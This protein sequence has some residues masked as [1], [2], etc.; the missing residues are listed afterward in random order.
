MRSH[1]SLV[2]LL[3]CLSFLVL[4]PAAAGADTRAGAVFTLSNDP[5]GNRVLIWERSANGS[6]HRAGSVATGG[7]GT[8]GSLGNQGALTL[9]A[10]DRWLYAVNPGS[11]EVSVFKVRGAHLTLMEVAPSGGDMPISVTARGHLV[12]VLNAGG[13]GNIAGFRRSSTGVLTPIVGSIEPLSG[14]ATGPAQIGF[15][16]N[17][18]RL[19]VTE[20]ATDRI[21]IYHLN[22]ADAA[23]A[24]HSRPSATATPFGFDFTSNGTLVVSE[25]AG[26][27]PDAG[28]TSSYRFGPSGGL[29]LVDGSVATTETA[30][31]WVVITDDDR[32]AYVTNTGSGTVSGY[33]ISAS[34]DLSLL[35]ADGVTASTG[36]GS[37]PIDA[38]LDGSSRHLY[39][40]LSGRDAIA[41]LLVRPD[42][43]LVE[44][45]H[46]AGLPDGANGLA[47][48]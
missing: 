5:D 29:H 27:A 47:A 14:P 38:A 6:L 4:A 15:S 31:C 33:R 40:L 37:G 34:G 24:P 35:D 30:A 21:T 12:Y 25:A 42:G 43:S 26:G 20:K 2:A 44:R 8:G 1:R 46:V 19:V 10:G 48:Y 45:G 28:V 9:G 11:D 16:P 3:A 13:E 23:G 39:V 41:I 22:A 36:D 7:T 18:R 17:G 32:Y